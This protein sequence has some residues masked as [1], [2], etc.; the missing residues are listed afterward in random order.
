MINNILNDEI[1]FNKKYKKNQDKVLKEI[2]EKG[3]KNQN[4]FLVKNDFTKLRQNLKFLLKANGDQNKALEFLQKKRLAKQEVNNLIDKLESEGLLISEKKDKGEEKFTKTFNLN[5]NLTKNWNSDFRSL[6]LDGNNML[7][8]DKVIRNLCLKGNKVLAEIILTKLSI[9]F[10]NNTDLEYL[11][12]IFDQTDLYF[13]S[14]DKKEV[15]EDNFN[16]YYNKSKI[17][18]EFVEKLS[19]KKLKISVMSAW[20]SYNIADDFLVDLSQKEDKISSLFVTSDKELQDRL[21][22]KGIKYIM[23][24]GG[25]FSLL[26]KAF[27]EE[28]FEMLKNDFANES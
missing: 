17:I 28:K 18:G 7:F 25:Y 14:L 22:S 19:P 8:V 26:I 12:V 6:Y 5:D 13:S 11:Y 15:K 4:E 21:F 10:S 2:E 24:S 1:Q 27:T 20:P 9:L 3:F 23:P 16:I